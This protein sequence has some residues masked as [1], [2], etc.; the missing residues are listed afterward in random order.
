MI[1]N[2]LGSKKRV[3]GQSVDPKNRNFIT[4]KY[5]IWAILADFADFNSGEN[6]RDSGEN[7]RDS[8]ENTRDRNLEHVGLYIF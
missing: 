3:H 7:R 5:S 2:R 8:G 4:L 1:F 6:R